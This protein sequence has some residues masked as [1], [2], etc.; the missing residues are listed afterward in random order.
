MMF[1]NIVDD[2]DV[3]LVIFAKDAVSVVFSL[4]NFVNEVI[5]IGLAIGIFNRDLG[6]VDCQEVFDCKQ[7]MRFAQA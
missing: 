6:F 7:E 2:Q 3:G 5:D 4:G 1:S